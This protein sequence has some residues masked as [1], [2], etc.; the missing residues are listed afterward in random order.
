[1]NEGI[2]LN[3]DVIICGAGPAGSTCA[4]AL[5]GSGLKV[6]L[7]DKQK[8]PRD[9]ICGDA[10]AA[11]VPKVLNSINPKFAE[12]L[13]AFQDK[14]PVN[15]LRLVAPNEKHIDL[16]Y[17]EWGF[18]A[19]RFS[20]DN[21]L[22]ELANAQPEVSCYLEHDIKNVLIEKDGVT[23]NSANGVTFHGKI[24]VGCDGA[25]SVVNKKLTDNKVDLAHH[26]G[27]VRAYYKGVEDIHNATF[28]LHFLKNVLP[29]YFWIFPL[30]NGHANVGLGMPSQTISNKKVNLREALNDVIENEPYIKK[31]FA[32]A[33]IVGQVRGYG[34]PLGS[35]KV[36]MSGNRFM[37]CG[38]A[39]SLID[40]VTGEGIGQAM[41]SGR[42]AGW[43]AVKCIAQSNYSP[44][45]MKQY[46]AQ[47]YAKFWATHR[48][49]Y[50]FQKVIDNRPWIINAAINAANSNPYCHDLM[51]KVLIW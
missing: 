15:T 40:P 46:D 38:D 37:L 12:G 33:E 35:R 44:K 48:K 26:S 1:M 14:Y 41:V 28:E 27:A 47:V 17:S 7:I 42:Y 29:G 25:H 18:V 30:P 4:L 50:L 43:H 11:Y 9:K 32:N 39:A 5:A 45:F 2:H 36:T 34:L 51:K 24:V 49:R 23:V 8:F 22:F 13:T 3:F 20:W 10:V 19:T 6:A 21:Y 31:R 16:E